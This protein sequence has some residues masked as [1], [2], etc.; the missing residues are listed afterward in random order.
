MP[1]GKWVAVWGSSPSEPAAVPAVYAKDIT[2]RFNLRSP[3]SGS[4]VRL[5]F[6]NL[7]GREDSVLTRVYLVKSGSP[8]APVTFGKAES[9]TL[10]AG[11][12]IVSDEIPFILKRND[13]YAVTVY[14]AGIT[15]LES[16]TKD[17]GP[18]CSFYYAEG[19]HAAEEILPSFHSTKIDNAYF[20]DTVDVFTEE[21]R[22]A[23]VVCFGDSITA[24]SWPDYLA[25]RMFRDDD[26]R[27]AVI[28][29]GIGGSRVLRRYEYLKD[30][31]Y[32][33]NGLTRFPR[34]IDSAGVDRVIVLHGINDIIHPGTGEFRPW[35]QLP[36][37]EDLICALKEYIRVG[38]EKG[39]KV[40]IATIPTIKGWTGYRAEREAVRHAVNEWIRTN[41]EAD[42]FVEF[43]GVT[44]SKEDPDMREALYD[45]GDH[46]H[47]SLA[48]AEH[49]AESVPQEYLET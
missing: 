20:L 10:E 44:R 36:K 24:Q 1:D 2:L 16:G 26:S 34:E 29:R 28:R 39:K 7:Y 40:Y 19:D 35:E 18:L 47:P 46:L 23:A 32:G 33:D 38:H 15:P 42:G 41:N 11:K 25:L 21:Q 37:P 4:C 45:S 49:M 31:H 17:T 13:E 14:I 5:H 12:Q 3:L 48:G 43:D 6:N 22:A 9:V 27:L 30:R 8:A